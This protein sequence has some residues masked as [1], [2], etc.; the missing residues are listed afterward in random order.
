M[1]DLQLECE[2]KKVS[3]VIHSASPQSGNHLICY[4]KDCQAFANHLDPQS[5][6]LN[7]YGGTRIYQCC[8]GSLE[9]TQGQEHIACLRLTEGGLYRW[10]TSCCNTPIGNT[11]GK[12][13]P[14]VGVIHRFIPVDQEQEKKLGPIL[15]SFHLKGATSRVPKEELGPASE[16]KLTFR[17]LRKLLAW[18]LG[19]LGKGHPFFSKDGE[20]IAKPEIVNKSP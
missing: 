14:F 6:T 20:P 12:G 7:Q 5:T 1:Q 19:S 18:K 17:V 2:C 16:A 9:I 3:G 4:C 10:Y 11:L 8:S 13:M 15:G